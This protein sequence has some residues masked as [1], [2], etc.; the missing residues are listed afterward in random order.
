MQMQSYGMIK[1]MRWQT[2]GLLIALALAAPGQARAA[3]L[4]EGF[5]ETA[6]ATGINGATAMDFAPDGRLFLCE[7]TGALRVLKN[8][9]LL[10][11]PFVPVKVDGS[12]ERG[13]LGVAFDPDFNKNHYVYVNYV[14][15]DP[16]P[17][18]RISRFTANGDRAVPGSEV[19]LFEGDN[20]EKL[21]GGSARHRWT[22]GDVPRGCRR[23]RSVALPMA[24][25]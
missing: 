12:W 8:D 7:Q 25:R 13:L 9:V 6:I 10:P 23:R 3:K 15:P 18:H 19:V 21:G 17:H 4:P 20:Q 1:A 2:A 11:L 14:C 16:Y 22:A 24:T 5:I